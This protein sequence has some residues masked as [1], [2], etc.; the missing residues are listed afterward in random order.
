MVFLSM[1]SASEIVFGKPEGNYHME[2]LGIDGSI[3]L[4]SVL[5]K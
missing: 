3:T 5:D 2:N 4:T 1:R